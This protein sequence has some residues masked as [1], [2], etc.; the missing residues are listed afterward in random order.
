MSHLCNASFSGQLHR[1]RE[2]GET[3]HFA[4]KISQMQPG[5]TRMSPWT[6]TFC[7]RVKGTMGVTMEEDPFWIAVVAAEDE[8]GEAAAAYARREADRCAAAGDVE[9][10]EIWAA[11]ANSLHILHAIN[12][13]WARS[14]RAP[15]LPTIR[16]R[17]DVRD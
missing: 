10:A 14:N 12:R 9:Q 5:L 7:L 8:H 11:A 2:T 15:L 4:R 13:Q 17:P 6:G 1:R 16:P 3:S